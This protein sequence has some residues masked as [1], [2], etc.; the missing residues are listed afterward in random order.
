MEDTED[1]PSEG[2]PPPLNVL[3]KAYIKIRAAMQQKEREHDAV[4]EG[5]LAQKNAIAMAMK[6]QMMAM[7][8][9]S[10]RT[11][12]GTVIITEKT[13]YYASD[14]DEMKKFVLEHEAV[15]LLEKRIAQKNMAEFLAQYPDLV[16]PGLNS[17]TEFDVT[18]RKPTN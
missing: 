4:M 15:D 2:Q 8:S 9:K 13:R 11:D 17:M 5:L 18:V 14:W 6:D 12:A 3:T 1:T 7:G 10:V 16:P